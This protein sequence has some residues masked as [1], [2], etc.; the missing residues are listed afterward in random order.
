MFNDLENS[1]LNN[2]Q[3]PDEERVGHITSF[4]GVVS[5]I[6][7]LFIG[8]AFSISVIALAY[9]FISMAMAQ[10][11][12]IAL[13]KAKNTAVFSVVAIIVSLMAVAIKNALFNSFGAAPDL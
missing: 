4:T 13:S 5:V 7:N 6:V 1:L 11:D 10:G 9:G 2:A 3:I 12:K 8:A